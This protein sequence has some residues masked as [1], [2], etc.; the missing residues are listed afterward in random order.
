MR[1]EGSR[2]DGSY[3]SDLQVV[4]DDV[5]LQG[6]ERKSC[7]HSLCRCQSSGFGPSAGEDQ[8]GIARQPQSDRHVVQ[9]PEV[10]H[11]FGAPRGY[12]LAQRTVAD[13]VESHSGRPR[14]EELKDSLATLKSA[15]ADPS[16]TWWRCQGERTIWDEVGD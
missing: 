6:D 14:V 4:R 13:D 11:V 5:S 16:R 10:A 3:T 15:H 7:G 9:R 8:A 2:D 1:R 12:L